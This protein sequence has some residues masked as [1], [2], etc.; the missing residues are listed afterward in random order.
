M[1]GQRLARTF[2]RCGAIHFG[3]RCDS[4]AVNGHGV[5]DVIRI[6]ARVSDHHGYVARAGD[7]KD[8]LV[9]P[10]QAFDGEVQTAKLVVSVRIGAGDVADQPRLKQP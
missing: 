8:E 5:A 1:E 3:G 2:T 9:A 7:A 6:A 10:F 4:V